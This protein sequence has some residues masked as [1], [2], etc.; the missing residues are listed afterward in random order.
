MTP[1]YS[2]QTAVAAAGSAVPLHAGLP[3]NGPLLVKALPSNSGLIYLGNVDG[4]V[5]SANGLP[6]ARGEAVVLGFV[7]NLNQLWIDAAVDGEKVAW[8]LLKP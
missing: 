8:L 2:G 7:G 6:L 3:V 1:T 5:D 4:D